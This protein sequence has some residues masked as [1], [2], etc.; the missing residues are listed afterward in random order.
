MS[1]IL[2][3][4]ADRAN[5]REMVKKVLGEGAVAHRRG[6]YQCEMKIT[7]IETGQVVKVIDAEVI[8]EHDRWWLIYQGTNKTRYPYP[9]LRSL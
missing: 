3:R 5:R 8:G 1:A 7:D 4:K 9:S 2:N 6:K